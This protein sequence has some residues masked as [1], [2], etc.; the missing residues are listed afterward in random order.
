MNRRGIDAR[1][2]E[3]ERKKQ[4][5]NIRAQG[6]IIPSEM[7]IP[8]PDPEKNPTPDDLEALQAPPDLLQ[9]LLMLEPAPLGGA[10]IGQQPQPQL[11]DEDK[12]EEFEICL[13]EPDR[14]DLGVDGVELGVQSDSDSSSISC[15]SI[16]RNAD[17]I[18]FN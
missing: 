16:A 11:G 3:K 17:F 4:V 5:Q 10:T 2:S 12:L 6:G 7:W 9:A 15:D 14:R 1:K 13:G 18:T 8:I